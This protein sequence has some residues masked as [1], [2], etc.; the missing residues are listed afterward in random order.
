MPRRSWKETRSP[1]GRNSAT[2]VPWAVTTEMK[3]ESA[4]E[5]PVGFLNRLGGLCPARRGA[6]GHRA[7]PLGVYAR[8]HPSEVSFVA[9]A[10]GQHDELRRVVRMLFDDKFLERLEL[11]SG[12][13][14]N[15]QHFGARLNL[16]LPPI[17]RFDS[18][19]QVRAGDE[20]G[21]EGRVC[22]QARS[23][24]IRGGDEN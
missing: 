8:T 11:R 1:A 6:V 22:K 18:G 15:D 19:N 17:V 7:L 3:S 13:F 9:S 24:R 10:D 23:R 16:A 4:V 5:S 20:A 21:F 12:G 2:S 14:E